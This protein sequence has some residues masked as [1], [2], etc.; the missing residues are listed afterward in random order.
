MKKSHT[1]PVLCFATAFCLAS[2]ALAQ[3]PAQTP[4]AGGPNNWEKE[5]ADGKA[6]YAAGNYREAEKQLKA[7]YKSTRE[8]ASNDPK[9][10]NTINDLAQVY[11]AES[12]YQDAEPLM[13]RYLTLRE[14]FLGKYHPDL[15][16]DLD[17]MGRVCFAQ[18]K[19]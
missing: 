1:N 4:A 2:A 13:D 7:A 17:A 3:A 11:R 6:A 9:L 16:K 14:R 18:M 8:F 5:Y 15:A 10:L 12:K 19:F